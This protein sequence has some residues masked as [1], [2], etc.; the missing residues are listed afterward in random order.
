ML[1]AIVQKAGYSPP[2][3]VVVRQIYAEIN[4]ISMRMTSTNTV[5]MMIQM[6][7]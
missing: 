4:G 3:L 6:I 7:K 2:N 1:H 5:T